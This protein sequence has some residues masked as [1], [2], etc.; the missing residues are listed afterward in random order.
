MDKEELIE[1][2]EGILGCIVGSNTT[3]QTPK[4]QMMD[5]IAEIKAKKIR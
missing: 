3:S 1:R 4:H 2:L 5:L